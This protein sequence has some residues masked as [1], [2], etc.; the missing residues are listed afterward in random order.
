MNKPILASL[1][2]CQST[3]LT[4]D[5]KYL[6]T[7]ANPLG[8]T[9]FSRNIADKTQ[10][11]NLINEIKE[12]IGR[13]DVLIAID[14]EGGRVR[15]LKEPD[16]RFYASQSVIGSL[17]LD[18]AEKAAKLHAS[19][20]ADDCQSLGINVNFAPVLDILHPQTTAAVAN[21]CFSA[22]ASIVAHLGEITTNE[23][24][25][26]GI[27]PC[28][29]HLPGHGLADTDSHLSLPIIN[30]PLEQ[31]IAELQPFKACN[32]SPL[33][34]TAHILLPAIDAQSPITQSAQG[35]QKIIREI[36]GFPGFLISDSVDMKA[37]K[38]S[39]AEKSLAS[40]AAGCDAV[41]YC[42]ADIEEMRSLVSVCPH[43]SDQSTER[44]DKAIKILHNP[45]KEINIEATAAEY[46]D[47]IGE[48]LPYKETFDATE[49]LHQI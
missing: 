45:I 25:S 1:L 7:Q 16:F 33:G 17:P 21:R 24:I 8:I 13:E 15:R 40:L 14:Q 30:A 36:I 35:I 19:L 47:L 49:V 4:D 10:L 37:L 28:I 44:L 20:I 23:Y 22:D 26:N 2:A 27:L 3:Q 46:A 39:V 18:K 41:C 6:F 34:M 29:K 48:T 12:V 32:F 42:K 43:L 38:G 11:K 9:L 5:E 31:I